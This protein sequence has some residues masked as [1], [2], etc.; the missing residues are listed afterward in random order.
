MIYGKD[1]VNQISLEMNFGTWS[2]KACGLLSIVLKALTLLIMQP[3]LSYIKYYFAT[4]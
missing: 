2:A 3:F 4:S 1:Q